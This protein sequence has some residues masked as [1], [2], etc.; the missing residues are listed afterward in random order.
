MKESDAMHMVLDLIWHGRY[1]RE[2]RDDIVIKKYVEFLTKEDT[3]PVEL[4]CSKCGKP[5]TTGNAIYDQECVQELLDAIEQLQ[6]ELDARPTTDEVDQLRDAIGAFEEEIT[7]LKDI[8]MDYE[9]QE[10][11]PTE[12]SDELEGELGK[13]QGV[14][15]DLVEEVE[16]KVK[17]EG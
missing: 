6:N 17:D 10:G 7:S 4:T 12:E 5:L 14:A 11:Q 2:G 9:M 15:D 13:V 16:G 3:M 1:F 8:I